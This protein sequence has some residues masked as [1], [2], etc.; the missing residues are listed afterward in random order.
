M[1]PP[2]ISSDVLY[3]LIMLAIGLTNGYGNAIC[4]LSASSIEHNH[5][6]KGYEDVDIAATLVGFLIVIGLAMGS[7]L[8]FGVRAAI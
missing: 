2:I 8:S 1:G 4:F 6:L 3:I 7:L 5:R